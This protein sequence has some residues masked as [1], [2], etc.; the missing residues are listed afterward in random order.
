M[1]AKQVII[2]SKQPGS[3]GNRYEFALWADVPGA[4][5]PAY[6]DFSLS[7][8]HRGI[9]LTELMALRMGQVYEK[10]VTIEYAPGTPQTSIDADI[11]IRWAEFQAEVSVLVPWPDY[12]RYWNGTVWSAGASPPDALR[13]AEGIQPTFFAMTPVVGFAANRFH[14]VLFNN[15]VYTKV[16]VLLVIVMPQA[17]AVTGVLPSAWALRRRIGPTTL[18]VGGLVTPVS[19]DSFDIIPG[20]IMLHSVPTTAP[21][22]GTVQD[23]LSVFPQPDEVK[24]STADAPTLASQSVFGGQAI[25]DASKFRPAI[26]LLLRP[27]ETLELQQSAT[28]GTGNSRIFCIFTIADERAGA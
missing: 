14:L 18:P 8:A 9:T 6:R 4:N 19:A 2:L 21:A 13:T 16:R 1:P 7:S 20:G 27:N 22:G 17:T 10:I 24:L 11:Q 5:Q 26:P 15:S 23:F 12:G 28:G 25:Y 3:S